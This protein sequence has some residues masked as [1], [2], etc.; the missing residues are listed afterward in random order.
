MAE[1][2]V[3]PS[4]YE[5]FGAPLIEAMALGCPVI[6][7]DST[8]I[9]AVV[10][11]AGLVLPLSTDAWADALDGSRAIVPTLDRRRAAASAVVHRREHPGAALAAR[12]PSRA[13]AV[14]NAR[15][16]ADRRAVPALRTRHRA[17]R[18]GDDPDRRRARRA[19]PRGARRHRAAVVPR[20]RRRG[21][22]GGPVGAPRERPTWGSITRVNPFPGGDKR[23][24]ARRAAGF[25]GFSALAGLASLRGGRVDAVIAMSPPLTMGLTGWVTHLVRRGPLVFN[26]QDV[27]PDA[28]VETGAITEQV[29][30]RRGP[31]AR[32]R[33][34]P[35]R[36]RGHR[37]QR[38]TCATTSPPRSGRRSKPTS[39]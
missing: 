18:R 14:V 16:A 34:L 31:V 33:Q 29:D 9:P 22:L 39:G 24:L 5:G 6:A 30:H 11:D 27:F 10:D 37:A 2:M 26:I 8:C 13:G 21:G 3:F 1:A 25:A 15:P 19:R 32:A 20:P 38:A 36:R 4:Q 23:N 12:V 35:P 7:S 28:A 17:D